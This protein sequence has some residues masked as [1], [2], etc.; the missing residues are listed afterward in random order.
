MYVVK[1]FSKTDSIILNVLG[2]A[3]RCYNCTA[4]DNGDECK[5]KV[6][7]KKFEVECIIPPVL[8]ETTK[9]M[10]DFTGKKIHSY[11]LEIN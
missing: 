2:S 9:S 1:S 6:N 8:S 4:K 10:F 7:Q 5:N 11:N 3:L